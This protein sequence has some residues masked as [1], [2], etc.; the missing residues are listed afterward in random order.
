MKWANALAAATAAIAAVSAHA[1]SNN[2][3]R[4]IMHEAERRCR[5]VPVDELERRFGQILVEAKVETAPASTD[6]AVCYF[7]FADPNAEFDLGKRNLHIMV[8]LDSRARSAP[9]ASA[10]LF[11]DK[12]RDGGFELNLLNAEAYYHFCEFG[13]VPAHT[14]LCVA[15]LKGRGRANVNAFAVDRKPSDQTSSLKKIDNRLWRQL[16]SLASDY[17]DRLNLR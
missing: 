12:E 3:P 9:G 11:A 17:A 1:Q 16:V 4:Q 10:T 2:D 14:R 13:N 8:A 15:A 6:V 7:D 5:L